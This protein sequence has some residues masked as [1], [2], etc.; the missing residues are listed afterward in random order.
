MIFPC[1]MDKKDLRYQT[2]AP[3]HARRKHLVGRHNQGVQFIP[4]VAMTGLSDPT[5]RATIDLFDVAGWAAMHPEIR[6]TPSQGVCP[7][8]TLLDRSSQ[9][10]PLKDPCTTPRQFYQNPIFKKWDCF[11]LYLRQKAAFYLSVPYFRQTYSL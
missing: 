4:I 1:V 3:L 11:C 5:V 8:G 6:G 10:A 2:L 9:K 7:E